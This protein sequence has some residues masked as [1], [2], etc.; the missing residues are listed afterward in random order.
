MD[1]ASSRGAVVSK[2]TFR[3]Y[4]FLLLIIGDNNKFL[5]RSWLKVEKEQNVLLELKID[6]SSYFVK[7]LNINF[8]S[9]K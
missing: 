7:N 1:F 4:F 9:N 6:L 2:K 3:I 5:V 8:I